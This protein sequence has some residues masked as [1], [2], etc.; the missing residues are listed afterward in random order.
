MDLAV[1]AAEAEAERT[2]WWFVGRRRLFGRLVAEFGV[3]AEAKI[4]DIGTSTG[5]NLRLLKELGFAHVEGLDNSETAIAFCKTKG[6]GQVK[7]GDVCALPFQSDSFDFVFATDII[8]HVDDDAQALAEILRVLRPGGRVLITVPAFPSL[9]GL[10]DD[11][12]LHKRRYR[13]S[14]LLPLIRSSGLIVEMRFH[15]NFLLF[16]PVWIA[17][18][19][20]RLAGIKLASETDIS[21]P[22]LNAVLKTIFEADIRLAPWLRPPFGVSILVVASRPLPPEPSRKDE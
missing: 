17:R 4:L 9:W 19:I 3:S 16:V 10:Q 2:H 14:G 7:L 13:M 15:F 18:K 12:S 11:Q 21:T 20:I 1:Y 5:T 22:L 8:E 6:L